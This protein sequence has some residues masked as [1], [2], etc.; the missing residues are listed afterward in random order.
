MPELQIVP[1]DLW[2]KVQQRLELHMVPRAAEGR[3]SVGT[4]LLS[5]FVK[6]A[7]CGSAYIKS[8]HSYRCGMHHNRGAAVCSN[9]RG[10]TVQKLQRVVLSVLRERLYTPEN[11]KAI[12]AKVRG[13]LLARAKQEDR[14]TRRPNDFAKELRAVETEIANIK[15]AVKLGTA[16]KTLLEMLEDSEERRKVLLADHDAPK[17]N[18]AQARLE[19][20]L[21][22]LP[23]RVQAYMEDLET[24][25]AK[26]QVERDKD[27]LASLGTEIVI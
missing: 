1:K 2:E 21:A 5:G 20:V 17:R 9:N 15:Q 22:E 8:N 16:T 13:E 26:R 11:M 23:K 19:N 7:V 12:I 14:L 6:C 10:V 27:M 25:L 3:H 4:Y 18:Y 24:L